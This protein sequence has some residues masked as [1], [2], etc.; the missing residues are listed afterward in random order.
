MGQT[1]H[2]FFHHSGQSPQ[3][4]G[5]DL[6]QSQILQKS[7][8]DLCNLWLLFPL[9]LRTVCVFRVFYG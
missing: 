8:C 2:G 7:L 6:K 3:G 4:I 5:E 1:D 9:G